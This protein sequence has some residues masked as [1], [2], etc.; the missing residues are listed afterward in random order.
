MTTDDFTDLLPGADSA[1]GSGSDAAL[2]QALTELRALAAGPQ[3]AATPELAAFLAQPIGAQTPTTDVALA[4]VPAA[5]RRARRG[6]RFFVGTAITAISQL[7]LGAKVAFAAGGVGVALA[8]GSTGI[9]PIHRDS[10]PAPIIT[11][12]P[13]PHRVTPMGEGSAGENE[14]DEGPASGSR[15][16]HPGDDSAKRSSGGAT[17][18]DRDD[19]EGHNN[20]SREDHREDEGY[21]QEHDDH[22]DDDS[23]DGHDDSDDGDDTSDD[24]DDSSDDAD[25]NGDDR[26][27]DD[28]DDRDDDSDD[29][30]DPDDDEEDRDDEH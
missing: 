14:V 8:A 27:E 7:G 29:P 24:G 21:D 13:S 18:P 22:G 9:V 28:E 1:A 25:D 12:S 11:Q 26:D 10:A 16:R 6:M 4:A 23:D 30:D 20:G 3:P 5:V 19:R 17:R 15:A 2:L